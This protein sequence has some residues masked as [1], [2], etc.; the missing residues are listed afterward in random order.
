MSL[1]RLEAAGSSIL[2]TFGLTFVVIN[3]RLSMAALGEVARYILHC[4]KGMD[5]M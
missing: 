4:R 3:A 2:S 5:A 1:R